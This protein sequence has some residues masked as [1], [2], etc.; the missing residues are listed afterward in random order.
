M[1]VSEAVVFRT[2]RKLVR[3]QLVLLGKVL[4]RDAAAADELLPAAAQ[5]FEREDADVRERALKLVERHVRK[6]RSAEVRT[7][8]AIAAERLGPALRARAVATLGAA[9]ADATATVYEEVLPP[10]PRPV[11]LAPAPAT[12]TVGGAGRAAASGAPADRRGTSRLV[13]EA[14]RLRGALKPVGVAA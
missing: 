2:E 5:A 12:V 14:R 11:R 3:A 4:T 8:L 6:V 1:E 13:R 7:E 9:P 10:V